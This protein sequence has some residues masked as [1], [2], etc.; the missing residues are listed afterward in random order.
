MAK[1]PQQIPPPPEPYRNRHRLFMLFAVCGCFLCALAGVVSGIPQLVAL[2]LLFGGALI[3]FWILFIPLAS[4]LLDWVST[5]GN[6]NTRFVTEYTCHCG[7]I[8][9]IPAEGS[10]SYCPRCRC[11]LSHNASG[12]G[13]EKLGDQCQRSF[14][15]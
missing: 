11:K 6:F 10:Y 12:L 15:Y 9:S 1:K 14:P 5:I 13:F 2:G 7:G 3:G 8:I 4:A